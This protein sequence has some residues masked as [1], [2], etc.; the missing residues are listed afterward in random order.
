MA[1]SQPTV[2]LFEKPDTGVD[3]TE[4][5]TIERL[6]ESAYVRL[7][8]QQ[9]HVPTERLDDPLAEY[10][11]L[12][13]R[14]EPTQLKLYCLLRASQQRRQNTGISKVLA[15]QAMGELIKNSAA[16]LPGTEQVIQSPAEF[17][18]AYRRL[19]PAGGPWW[20]RTVADLGPQTPASH[21]T[22]TFVQ[23]INDHLRTFRTQRL[24]QKITAQVQAGERVL[25]VLDQRHL[26]A[27]AA[28]AVRA[29]ASR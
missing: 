20:Q 2:V 21:P 8:A 14:V 12:R 28:Y 23:A 26:P 29:Q 19:C 15:T 22:E 4:A 7:L 5:T 25:V 16:F 18:A 3:S 10:E 1:A 9:H 27:P 6:G 13:A 17:A 11:Y 24:N